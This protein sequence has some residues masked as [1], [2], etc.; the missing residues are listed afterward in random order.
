MFVLV[1]LPV[2]EDAPCLTES[3]IKE[4]YGICPCQVA[5]PSFTG[6]SLEG[7]VNQVERLSSLEKS[8][9]GLLK[10]FMGYSCE[11]SA[12]AMCDS[13]EK[14]KDFLRWDTQSFVTNSIDKAILLLEG[15]YKRVSKAYEE[16][17]EEFNEAKKE[18]DKLQKLTRGNLCD[19][20]LSIIVG[21]EE[22]YEFLKVLYVIVQKSK[23]SEFNRIVDESPHISPEVVEKINS[24]EDHDLFKFYILHCSEEEVRNAMHAEGFLV[25]ELDENTMSSEE[26]IAERRK[27]EERFSAIE[28]VLMTFVHVHLTEALKILIHVKLLRLFV[29]SVYRYGLPTEYMFFVTSGEKSRI[30]SQWTTIAKKWP[31]DR[32]VYEEEG[33]NNEEGEVFFAFSEIEICGEE[34]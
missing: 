4:E 1:G 13:I 12:K 19:I 26:I 25:R 15:E 16:K 2:E 3:Q 22:K 29:E 27:A 9:E 34:E 18:C 23:A 5:L 6:V 21:K 7:I 8:C 20:N 24:D 28:R 14:I 30:L 10:T 31:S 33:D 11:G 32:I 17:V